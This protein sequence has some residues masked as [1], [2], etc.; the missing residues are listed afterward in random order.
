MIERDRIEGLTELMAELEQDLD[1][2]DSLTGRRH[3]GVEL[4]V[5]VVIGLVA[6]LALSNLYFVNDLTD[7]V[8]LVITRMQEMNSLFTR[9][10]VRM[11]QISTE[12]DAIERNVLLMP[13]VAEQMR[14]MSGH[15]AVM[16]QSVSFMDRAAAGLVDSVSIMDGNLR[17]IAVRFH[18]LNRSVGAMG[19]D[20]NQMARPLP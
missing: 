1:R 14:E 16:E 20:V 7:E 19:V 13:V 10:S 6:A 9:V 3:R 18:G 15:V 12:I 2:S 5:R 11:D 8:R 4:W 17:D